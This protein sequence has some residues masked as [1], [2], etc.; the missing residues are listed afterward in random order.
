MKDYLEQNK[1]WNKPVKNWTQT[2]YTRLLEM[3]YIT[4]RPTIKDI[5]EDRINK[6][7]KTRYDLEN[8][9]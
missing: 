1:L 2:R 8:V 3:P 5:L 9:L 4:L 7:L 6:P